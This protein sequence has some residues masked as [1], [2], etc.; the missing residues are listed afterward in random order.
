MIIFPAPDAPR[1][2]HSTITIDDLLLGFELDGVTWLFTN[3]KGWTMGSGVDR[4]STPR[5]G[6]HG[7]FDTPSYR[8]SRVIT[9]D[10][11]CIADDADTAELANRRLAALLADGRVGDF[12]VETPL[13]ILTAQVRISDT[14]IDTWLDELAFTW[15]LQFT[16]PDWRKYGEP[17]SADT[18]LPGGGT[19][20]AYNLA[21]PLD[22]GDPG[23]TGR[24][25]FTNTGDA[26]TEPT[27]TVKAPMG[28]GFEITR[29]ETGQRLRYAH[30]VGSDLTI[31]CAAGTVLEAG[32]RRERYLTV[33]EW[34]SVLPGETA[35]FQFSTLGSET[36]ADPAHLSGQMA[37][38]YP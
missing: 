1:L 17:Q 2:S 31:D 33:R 27:F 18:S 29:V 8:R 37:P 12:S 23:N 26:A 21:Y 9:V 24:I 14:P 7:D 30:P 6:Q 11:V 4:Q 22:Y 32:Q 25:S 28:V 34:P 15:S 36:T 20:L 10:G 38:A 35:T 13:G 5:P 3:L 19:G 16:A